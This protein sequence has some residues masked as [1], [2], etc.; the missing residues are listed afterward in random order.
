MRIRYEKLGG[1]YHCAVF[2]ARVPNQTYA[3]CGDLV[4]DELEFE[5]VKRIMSGAQFLE[6]KKP[7]ENLY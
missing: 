5:D 4:F 6:R 7:D 2:T 1:H 3:K